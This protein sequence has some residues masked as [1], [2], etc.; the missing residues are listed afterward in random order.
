MTQRLL[1]A[2]ILASC[3]VVAAAQEREIPKDS[4]LVTLQ[5]CADGRSFIVAPRSEHAPGTLEIEAGRRFRMNGKKEVLERI[6]QN[7]DYVIEITGLIR[8]VDLAKPGGISL[9][10]GRVRI[11]GADPRQPVGPAAQQAIYNQAV[12][13]VESSRTFSDR[14]CPIR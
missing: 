9:A 4:A 5:G 11:G 13:D 6:E 1:A 8:K 3:S 2:A 10:G 7:E 14:R 12:I